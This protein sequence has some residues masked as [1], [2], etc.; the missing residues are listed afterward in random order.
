MTHDFVIGFVC[1]MAFSVV[2]MIAG[3]IYGFFL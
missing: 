3:G 1:G 2:I